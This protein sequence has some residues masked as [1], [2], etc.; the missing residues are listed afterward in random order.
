MAW[1][2]PKTWSAGETLT[3]ANFNAHV[4][5]NLNAVGPH[6]IV[7]KTSDE[8]VTSSTVMQADNVLIL[9]VLASEV[10]MVDW[11][12]L[13][14]S[15]PGG[16]D[17]RWT[18]PSGGTLS[19]AWVPNAAL[20][21]QFVDTGTSP[22]AD[23]AFGTESAG[24]FRSIIVHGIYVNGGSGGNVTLEWAQTTS[25]GTGTVMKANSTL[26]AVKLA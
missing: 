23:Q 16:M 11:R 4:R 21:Y 7:R 1:T 13:V 5:D 19:F 20:G 9:P 15:G 18:F 26:W 2:T 10:W 14:D 3:A 17:V 25:D 24:E 12:L 8:T 22:T 6:L